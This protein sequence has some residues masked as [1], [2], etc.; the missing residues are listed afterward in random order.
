[1]LIVVDRGG[2][3]TPDS[4]YNAIWLADV[5][6]RMIRN[7]VFMV[8]HWMLT[9]KGGY[10]GWGLVGQS[11]TY[12]GYH[13]YQTYKK[14]GTKLVYSASPAPDLSIYAAKRPDGTLTLLIINLAD[15]PRLP[16][17]ARR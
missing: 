5:L 7:G 17:K 16:C 4:H 10:G 6:G 3:G 2:E 15:G 1:M 8:N 12:P 11:E 14:F 9:S 13:V